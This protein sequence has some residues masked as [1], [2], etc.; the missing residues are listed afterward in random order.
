VRIT[1]VSITLLVLSCAGQTPEQE[2]DEEPKGAA[3]AAAIVAPA[4]AHYDV[5]DARA[6]GGPWVCLGAERAG[7]VSIV[8]RLLEPVVEGVLLL[9]D[10]QGVVVRAEKVREGQETVELLEAV[11][12][13]SPSR[14]VHIEATKGSSVFELRWRY[15]DL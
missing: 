15:R 11:P 3:P 14:C 1:A 5:I 4:R 9:T 12:P 6:T 13:G 2:P 10:P 8:V 7:D